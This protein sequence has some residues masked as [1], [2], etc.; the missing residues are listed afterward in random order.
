MSED[1]YI[2]TNNH[3]VEDA[4]QV[5]V[6]LS[7]GTQMPAEII[8]TDEQTDLAV[9]EVEP[10]GTLTA[11]EFGNSDELQPGQ[12]AYALGSPGGVQFANTITGGRISAINRDV[13]V[14]NDRV[15]TLIQTDASIQ[16]GQLG[17]R[18]D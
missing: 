3:V 10:D 11:A 7:D 2:I 15:V 1:G 9:L 18:A 4:E 16:P 12:Y 6:Q 8:G 5:M 17:R 13:T 14:F